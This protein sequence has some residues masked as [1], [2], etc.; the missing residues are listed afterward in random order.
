MTVYYGSSSRFEKLRIA[1]YLIKS[2]AI[3]LTEE[4]GIYNQ[5]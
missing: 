5:Q 2:N 3:M 4:M 1:K